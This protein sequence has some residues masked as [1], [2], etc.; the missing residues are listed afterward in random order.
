M[1]TD[2]RQP[3][4]PV[5]AVDAPSC[6]LLAV[7][8]GIVA[9]SLTVFVLIADDLLDGGG[10][11]AHDKAVLAWFV[12]I[13]TNALVTLAKIISVLGSFP[14][15]SAFAVL[16][17]VVLLWRG[18]PLLL[19]VSPLVALLLAGLA[20]T[21]AKDLFGRPRPP[22]AVHATSVTL[23]AFPSG[24][25]TDAAACLFATSV[26]L[27]LTIAERRREQ[28]LYVAAGLAVAA[29]VGL[30]RLVLGVHWMSDVVAGWALGLAISVVVVVGSWCWVAH[31]VR[32]VRETGPGR[33]ITNGGGEDGPG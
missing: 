32:P 20:S 4:A 19:A 27:A 6:R 15:L 21:G 30:S 17:A 3:R 1:T 5:R 11:I 9:C 22:I 28:G 29:G 25:A 14:A 2:V 7:A 12:G 31:R 26:V 8:A 24:H 23:P 10:L 13:R 33:S 16:V 18:R